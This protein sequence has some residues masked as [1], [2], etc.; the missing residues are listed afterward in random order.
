MV[1]RACPM[2][3]KRRA[4]R[5]VDYQTKEYWNKLLAQEGL[6]VDAGRHPKL[7]YVGGAVDIEY[8]EG[9]RRTDTG[10]ITTSEEGD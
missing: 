8:I 5:S 4:L 2:A 3:R 10:R 7:S 9:A 1:W 6:S